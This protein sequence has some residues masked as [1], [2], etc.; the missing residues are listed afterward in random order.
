MDL[1]TVSSPEHHNLLNSAI[2]CPVPQSMQL[3]TKFLSWYNY[4]EKN[5]RHF[6]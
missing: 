6:I 5:R 4:P 3:L 1:V 2:Q